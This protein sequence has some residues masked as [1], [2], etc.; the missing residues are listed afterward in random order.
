MTVL[1]D[2]VICLGLA[3][4]LA[5]LV[6]G[7]VS[8]TRD[9]AH[10]RKDQFLRERQAR[11]LMVD[12]KARYGPREGVLRLKEDLQASRTRLERLAARWKKCQREAELAL[13]VTNRRLL[14]EEERKA[15]QAFLAEANRLRVLKEAGERMRG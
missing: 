5:G 2:P 11:M 7:F 6:R 1:S 13:Q 12:Y 14:Q 9:L 8:F 10:R 3:L 4:L 15:Y